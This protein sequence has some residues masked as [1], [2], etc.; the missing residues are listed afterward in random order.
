MLRINPAAS[1]NGLKNSITTSSLLLLILLL[2]GLVRGDDLTGLPQN[3]P[4]DLLAYSAPRQA[5]V[6]LM[7]Q[8]L[9][10]WSHA[11]ATLSTL[12]DQLKPMGTKVSVLTT[13]PTPASSTPTT[14]KVTTTAAPP[15][16][17]TASK[18]KAASSPADSNPAMVTV[19]PFL[20]W[21][22]SN[23]QAAAEARQQANNY[24][25][26]PGSPGIN[27]NSPAN[28]TAGSTEITQDPYWLPPMIDSGDSAPRAIAGS[29]AIYQ[30]PQ[31]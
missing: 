2:P 15:S 30:T 11:P 12:P 16:S 10:S 28:T 26:A 6:G 17:E 19:S 20:Q 7:F 8:P 14:S 13:P 18:D 1:H 4:K 21:I 3:D 29:A 23:P 24:R 22:K 27:G 5:P 31:R 25:P 9:P